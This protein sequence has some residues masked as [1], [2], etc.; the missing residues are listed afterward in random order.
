[1]E[2]IRRWF[3]LG[4]ARP[5]ADDKRARRS[6]GVLRGT[7]AAVAARG[8]GTVVGL[9]TV[10]LTL[11]YLGAERYGIWVTISTLLAFLSF[12]DF[13]IANS[14]SNALGKAYGE[15]QPEIAAR[16]V[17]SAFFLFCLIAAAVISAAVFFAPELATLCFPNL[18][19]TQARA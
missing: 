19:S 2:R 17:S 13:G 8:V 6:Q 9:A 11:G 15:G 18:Q 5:S 4:L 7:I 3:T 12:S 1:M 10:P 16:Y 14:L